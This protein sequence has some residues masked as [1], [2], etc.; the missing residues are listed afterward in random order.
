M[1][2]GWEWQL[3]RRA[4]EQ[5]RIHKTHVLAAERPRG[6]LP[7]PLVVTKYTADAGETATLSNAAKLCRIMRR[8]PE[9]LHTFLQAQLGPSSSHTGPSNAPRF[10][11]RLSPSAATPEERCAEAL[12]RYLTRFVLCDCCG[13]RCSHPPVCGCV[14]LNR[15]LRHT[16]P[17]TT[18]SPATRIDTCARG[19][20][21]KSCEQ[22]REGPVVRRRMCAVGPRSRQSLTRRGRADVSQCG[23]QRAVVV[24]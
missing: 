23:E 20:A 7:P 14:S 12:W 6:P 3:L 8:E 18:Q 10:S 5:L 17:P 19:T 15:D 11:F 1:T 2:T 4:H 16:P 21:S 9:H 22:V 13:V 24:D